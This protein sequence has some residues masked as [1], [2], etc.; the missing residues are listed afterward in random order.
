M[1]IPADEWLRAFLLTLV[2]EVP[3]ATYLLRHNEPRLSRAAAL[4][5]FANLASHPLVWFVWSQVFLIGTVEYVLVAEM[6]AVAV[7]AVFFA[8]AV[9]GLRPGR[10]LLVSL[11]ANGASF[12]AGRLL[13]QLF[14][15][16]F[17]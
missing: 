11:V 1:F 5:V 8:V 17:R 16:I 14:P 15:E 6:W 13:I 12:V 10:A 4:V 7:E 9:R 3:V 2:V